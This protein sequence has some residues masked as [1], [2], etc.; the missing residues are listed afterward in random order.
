VLWIGRW[1]VSKGKM[2]RTEKTIACDL[3]FILDALTLNVVLFFPAKTEFQYF[4][5][6]QT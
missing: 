2:H 1:G 3:F 4:L 5:R 6:G